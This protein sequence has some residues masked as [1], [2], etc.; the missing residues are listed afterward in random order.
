M[1]LTPSRA[2][3]TLIKRFE[4]C[5]LEAYPDPGTGNDPWTVG[6]G[7]TGPGIR[8]GVVWTEAPRRRQGGRGG[9]VRQ[10]G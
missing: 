5:V 9:S 2:C 6:W 1:T 7:S 8:K 3:L 10:M 4:G